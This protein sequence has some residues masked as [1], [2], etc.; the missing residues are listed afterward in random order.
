MG[1]K[2]KNARQA[3]L[4]KVEQKGREFAMTIESSCPKSPE[5][6]KA[7]MFLRHALEW[8]EQSILGEP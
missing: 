1:P 5:K 7:F 6:I 4:L 8:A 3:A 2:E